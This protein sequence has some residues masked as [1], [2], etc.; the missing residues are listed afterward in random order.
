[1]KS[2]L[3][4]VVIGSTNRGGYGHGLDTA[5]AD[6]AL[7]EVVAIADDNA[8]GLAEA[9]KKLGVSKLYADWRKMIQKEKPGVVSIGPRWITDR[10]A[11]A[12]AAAG[13]GCHIYCEKP[14]AGTLADADRMIAAVQKAKV[15]A[16]VAHQFRAMPPVRKALADLQAGKFG[17]LLRMHARPKDDPRGGGEELVVHGT[18]L[19]DLMIMFAGPPQW[20]AGHVT[21]GERAATKDDRREGTEPVGPIAGDGVE[22]SFGFEG[23]VVGSFFSRAKLHR[24][25]QDLY[26]LLMECEQAMLSIRSPGDVFVYPAAAVQADNSKLTWEKTWIE[27]WH[28]T[29]EHLPRPMNDW[30]HRGN[31]TMVRELA[32][33]IGT[34][35]EPPASLAD[36]HRVTEMIQGV[37][38]SHFQEGRRL[39]L[40]L[41]AR[42]HPLEG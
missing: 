7:F 19:F 10:V 22:A 14:L 35:R 9:G 24:S 2:P 23:S 1:M 21:V 16:S 37:Y 3:R 8:Q 27:E 25:G 12:E 11:M 4:V 42:K 6:R 20:V 36:A 39:K 29:P 41:E 15:K 18:H 17:K 30:I 34:D 40:P 38:A 33:S 31:L 13:A 26:G 28:F 5:F 32:E